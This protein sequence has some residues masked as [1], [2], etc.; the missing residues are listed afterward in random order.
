MLDVNG[1]DQI[2]DVDIR[3]V[4]DDIW[5]GVVEQLSVFENI[6]EA[7]EERWTEINSDDLQ[8]PEFHNRESFSDFVDHSGPTFDRDEL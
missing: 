5:N 1:D 7:F 4:S 8:H 6:V 2:D 3:K